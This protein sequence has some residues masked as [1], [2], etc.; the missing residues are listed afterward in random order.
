MKIPKGPTRY[1]SCHD[2]SSL[3]TL[4]PKLHKL[5]IL[6]YEISMDVKISQKLTQ[7]GFGR[8]NWLNQDLKSA[9]TNFAFFLIKKGREYKI[10]NKDEVLNN[11]YNIKWIKS[12]I[13][14]LFQ[15][16]KQTI[17]EKALETFPV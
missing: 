6:S 2:L 9:V 3:Q 16:Y 12:H 11:L 7:M 13:N 5:E 8:E 15:L 17:N 10:E 4:N 14:N 1:Y